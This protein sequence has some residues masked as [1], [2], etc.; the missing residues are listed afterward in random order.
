MT[1][2]IWCSRKAYFWK[3]VRRPVAAG[4]WERER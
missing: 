3:I 1:P 2:I 4:G